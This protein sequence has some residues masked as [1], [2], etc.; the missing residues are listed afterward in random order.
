MTVTVEPSLV[1]RVY[2]TSDE[3]TNLIAFKFTLPSIEGTVIGARLYLAT[4]SKSGIPD[5]NYLSKTSADA[6][7][8][9]LST[10]ATIAGI[11]MTSTIET[12]NATAISGVSGDW[13]S[14]DVFTTGTNSISDAYAGTPG[15]FTVILDSDFTTLTGSTEQQTVVITMLED[16]TNTQTSFHGPSSATTP[17]RPYL[18][19]EYTL[20]GDIPTNTALFLV[21]F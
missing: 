20:G 5:A 13:T 19:I 14:W 16:G 1:M 3:D 11:S 15:D 8:T 7:W 6:S 17:L 4:N 2:D 21:F 12:I 9:N 10:G 18:E